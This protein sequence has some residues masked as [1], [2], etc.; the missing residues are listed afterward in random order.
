MTVRWTIDHG[1]RLV[2]VVAEGETQVSDLAGL[3]DAIE[4]ANAVPYRKIIDVS[5]VTGRPHGRD[6]QP[7]AERVARYRNPGPFAV[8]VAASG[9]TD[10]LARLFIL[11]ADATDRARVFRNAAEAR[12]W[13]DSL[14]VHPPIQRQA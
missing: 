7:F 13:I 6:M 3:L 12:Q 10:G 5:G 11:I 4:A 1:A 8:V 9:P 2:D 14:A